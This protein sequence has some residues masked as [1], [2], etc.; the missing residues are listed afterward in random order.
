MTKD[1]KQK[2]FL[3]FYSTSKFIDYITSNFN[4]SRGRDIRGKHAWEPF[5]RFKEE[6]DNEKSF[7]TWQG[8]TTVP[9]WLIE[10]TQTQDILNNSDG[11]KI[12]AIGIIPIGWD[13]N[14]HLDWDLQPTKPYRTF[15]TQEYATDTYTVSLTVGKD[16]DAFLKVWGDPCQVDSFRI[17]TYCGGVSKEFRI[18]Y[19]SK[20]NI[21]DIRLYENFVCDAEYDQNLWKFIHAK[22]NNALYKDPI[23]YKPRQKRQKEIDDE[24]Q[25][26]Y[27]SRIK[28]GRRATGWDHISGGVGKNPMASQAISLIFKNIWPGAKHLTGCETMIVLHGY[29]NRQVLTQNETKK[30]KFMRGAGIFTDTYCVTRATVE[31]AYN[32]PYP[33]GIRV[34]DIYDRIEQAIDNKEPILNIPYLYHHSEILDKALKDIKKKKRVTPFVRWKDELDWPIGSLDSSYRPGYDI[35]YMNAWIDYGDTATKITSDILSMDRRNIV[36]PQLRQNTVTMLDAA[37]LGLT[38]IPVVAAEFSY[39]SDIINMLDNAGVSYKKI[40]RNGK[41]IP[42]LNS[43]VTSEYIIDK[44]NKR[45]LTLNE[46]VSLIQIM[47][48]LKDNPTS[49][50]NII[51]T[52]TL[53]NNNELYFK[54]FNW[55]TKKLFANHPALTAIANKIYKDEPTATLARECEKFIKNNKRSGQWFVHK[56]SRGFS[57]DPLNTYVPWNLKNFIDMA[58]EFMRTLRLD[59]PNNNYGYLVMCVVINDIDDKAKPSIEVETYKKFQ[60]LTELGFPVT[61]WIESGFKSKSQP[62]GKKTPGTFVLNKPV[63]LTLGDLQNIIRGNRNYRNSYI[64]NEY[65]E[66]HS[67]YTDRFLTLENPTNAHAV[68]ELHKWFSK[69]YESLIEMSAMPKKGKK[70]NHKGWARGFI[71]GTHRFLADYEK[72]QRNVSRMNTFKETFTKKRNNRFN[73]LSIE[74]RRELDKPEYMWSYEAPKTPEFQKQ[75]EKWFKKFKIPDNEGSRSSW[76]KFRLGT[77]NWYDEDTKTDHQEWLYIRNERILNEVEKNLDWLC[78]L[79]IMITF[80]DFYEKFPYWGYHFAS[81]LFY[82]YNPKFKQQPAK[83]LMEDDRCV[84]AIKRWQNHQGKIT[85]KNCHTKEI[86]QAAKYWFENIAPWHTVSN[87]TTVGSKYEKRSLYVIRTLQAKGITVTDSEVSAN[88]TPL[89]FKKMRTNYKEFDVDTSYEKE[90]LKWAEERNTRIRKKILDLK[91]RKDSK[92][93]TMAE[94]LRTTGMNRLTFDDRL[95][96]YT[97]E[98]V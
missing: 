27:S 46:L 5:I 25:K 86:W 36:G 41:F 63:N 65:V 12:D 4:D 69:K 49:M 84:N 70:T 67:D 80:P 71:R 32:V 61:E 1:F 29:H 90:M 30:Q 79:D 37:N 88:L 97:K 34:R 60:S 19:A 51:F 6:Y 18:Q 20:K 77:H 40:K 62:G 75:R 17:N 57:V 93:I 42:D 9:K 52:A 64:V 33:Q 15:V 87:H 31:D 85:K 10:Q 76:R 89:Q 35:N 26:Y 45:Y 47:T 28:Q 23:K 66:A 11:R 59:G 22:I 73:Q 14:D 74:L 3:K 54:N 68:A 56:A 82:S 81:N 13:I 38:K 43:Y 94:I 39:M 96:Q 83:F 55:L 72:I 48:V 21:P 92:A 50:T 91:V 98:T 16:K 95:R 78:S 53:H 58:Q 8:L 2:D 7:S 24:R 44:G